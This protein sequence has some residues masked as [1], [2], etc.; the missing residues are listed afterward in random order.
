MNLFHLPKTEPST[1]EELSIDK[2]I[3]QVK[4][5]LPADED[6]TMLKLAYDFAAE[7]H[8]GQTRISGDLYISHP[9]ATTYNLTVMKADMPT[10]LAGLLHDVPEDTTISIQEIE[11]NFGK[12]VAKLVNGITKLGRI[13]YRGIERYAENLR[14]MFIAMANDI[15]VIFIK[16]ADRLH[17]LQTIQYLPTEKQKRIALETLEIY[18]PIAD[19]LGMGEIKHQLED[20]SFAIL[21]PDEYN[22]VMSLRQEPLSRQ[23]KNLSKIKKILEENFK[24]ENLNYISIH[25]RTKKIFSLYRKLLEKDRD[26]NRIYDLIALRIIVPNIQSCYTAIGIIHSIWSPLKGRIKDYIATPKPNGYQS[27]HTTVFATDGQIVEFQVRTIEMHEQ[28]EYG[29]A[30]HW[31]YKEKGSIKLSDKQQKWI[32]QLIAIQKKVK[33][34]EQYLQ[35]IKLDIFSDQIYI[36][37]PKGD[38]IEL[39]EGSTPIDFA[40]HVHTELGN[41]CIGAKINEQIAP[42][43]TKLLSGDMVEIMINKNRK[44]PNEDWLKI[45]KTKSAKDHIKQAINKDSK[46]RWHLKSP[47]N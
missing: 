40:Y 2:L 4:K 12:E 8:K 5:Y 28:A 24:K 43:D 21:Q 25:G 13:K 30:A 33:D 3:D 46:S 6:F 1:S 26:I 15:R 47:F 42:L 45:V 19:R 11:K 31:H 22:W 9:L 27:I 32:K 16:F 7:A 23:I 29:I 39:P 18:A 38:V 36:F 17:N 37:T 14:K 10:L 20:L 44:K 41:K 34:N 35:Q